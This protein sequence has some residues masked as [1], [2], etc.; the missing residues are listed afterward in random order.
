MSSPTTSEPPD[1]RWHG[2]CNTLSWGHHRTVDLNVGA[3]RPIALEVADGAA[4]M[5][6]PDNGLLAPAVGMLGG[7][8]RC[9]PRPHRR[10][11]AGPE[12]TFPGRDPFAPVAAR[13]RALGVD[14]AD[15]GTEVDPATLT[16]GMV[17]LTTAS[18]RRRGRARMPRYVVDRFGNV[19]L[20]VDPDEIAWGDPVHITV[21]ERLR[22]ART[23]RA[24]SELTTGEIG[25]LVDAHGLMTLVANCS[26][27]DELQ[28]AGRRRAVGARFGD[29]APQPEPEGVRS[30]GSPVGCPSTPMPREDR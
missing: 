26:A 10:A 27:A 12:R 20:N 30:R 1:S 18:N 14:L 29:D 6:G 16:P 13:L 24:F 17:P 3:S 5:L 8:G 15:L 2:P 7:A 19:Q 23:I 9:R 21:G 28:L 22:S 25:L 4:V 11:S